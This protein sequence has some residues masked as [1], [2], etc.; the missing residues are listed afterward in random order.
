MMRRWARLALVLATALGAAG[1]ASAVHADTAQRSPSAGVAERRTEAP[2]NS[3]LVAQLDDAVAW[4]HAKASNSVD[5]LK[6]FKH[7]FPASPHIAEADRAIADLQ[8]AEAWDRAK[9][10]NTVADLQDFKQRFPN[11]THLGD[12]NRA[13]GVL[14][15]T[16][17]WDRAKNSNLIADLQDFKQRFPN[18]THLGEA[19]KAIGV[20]QELEAWDRAKNSNTIAGLEDF[21]QRYPNSPHLGDANKAIGVLQELEAW[22][23]AKNSNTIAGLEDFKQRYPNSPHL[24]DANKAIGVL[25]ELEAWDRAKNS[26]TIAGLQDFKQRFPNSPHLAEA[27]NAIAVLQDAE[28]W[29]R[30][31]KS[32]TIADLQ[33]FKQRFP[34]SPHLAEGDKAIAALQAAGEK[35]KEEDKRKLDE[36]E[37]ARQAAKEMEESCQREA[38]QVDDFVKARSTG[39]LNALRSR[40]ACPRTL[41]AI[42]KG[43]RDVQAQECDSE[44]GQV[45]DLGTDL[46]ALKRAVAGF[47]CDAV[48]VVARGR[49]A[50]LEQ[51]AAR[52]AKACDDAKFEVD[53]KID[54]F[55]AGA[56][57]K[58]A[59]YLARS[60]CPD[61]QADAQQRISDIDER[62]S[63][64]QDQL[65]KLGCYKAEPASKRFDGETE[66]AIVQFQRGAKLSVDGTHLSPDFIQTLAAY[67]GEDACPAQAAPPPV[68]S[69]PPPETPSETPREKSRAPLRQRA[70]PTPAPRAE[71]RKRRQE[72]EGGGAPQPRHAAP[73]APA[74]PAAAPSAAKPQIF[75]PN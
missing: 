24:G 11:S 66:A 69:I 65:K 19:N 2:P 28:A 33:D 5:E 8:E 50:Q 47:A 29:D 60:E 17:A 57:E 43:L 59:A 49:I 4:D 46:D 3:L 71:P 44:R 72:A 55:A 16:V 61:A 62:V 75:I 13:I 30:A 15:E 45:R 27:D 22:D 38:A 21:K 73:A 42:D 6:A 68:A 37:K 58:L 31:K 36:A 25:Q 39:A 40:A 63:N 18:S 7:F 26:N 20:L 70:E 1:V 41:A 74:A 48:A 9:K 51:E 54:A 34:N 14:Q 67:T 64:A 35:E 32:N 56:R 23:R 52:V 53:S 10:S 12:A